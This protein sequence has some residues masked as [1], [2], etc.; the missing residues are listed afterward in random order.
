MY[1]EIFFV[2]ISVLPPPGPR[3]GDLAWPSEPVQLPVE[4]RIESDPEH[5]GERERA[6]AVH[7]QSFVMAG[8][9]Y[10]AVWTAV[11]NLRMDCVG[12]PSE[13]AV[14]PV[15]E[16]RGIGRLGEG[17]ARLRRI[18]GLAERG[19]VHEQE[20]P[21]ALLDDGPHEERRVAER[22]RGAQHPVHEEIKEPF[23]AVFI[24]RHRIPPARLSCGA[25]ILQDPFDLLRSPL[26]RHEDEP[27]VRIVIYQGDEERLLSRPKAEELPV[28]RFDDG[29]DEPALGQ[30]NRRHLRRPDDRGGHC[31]DD[32]PG[33]TLGQGVRHDESIPTDDRGRFDVRHVRELGDRLFEAGP[34]VR[35]AGTSWAR[36]IPAIDWTARS[37]LRWMRPMF[38]SLRSIVT[39]IASSPAPVAIIFPMWVSTIDWL[40]KPRPISIAAISEV[41]TIAAAIAAI[42]FGS[43]FLGSEWAIRMPSLRAIVAPRMPGSRRNSASTA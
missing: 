16:A 34:D 12:V 6:D 1:V 2:S 28:I 17:L 26:H 31:R 36:R 19:Q 7:G 22:F 9:A 35:H 40:N 37:T 29:P 8:R 10:A 5:L 32:L 23:R 27:Q 4:I 18:V 25:P 42:F 14:T 11:A 24:R 15:E 39:R 43:M 21:E 3:K 20:L 41:P 33:D 30:L 38:A 13:H